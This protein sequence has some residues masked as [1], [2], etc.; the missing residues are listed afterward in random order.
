MADIFPPDLSSGVGR[1]RKNRSREEVRYRDGQ[2]RKQCVRCGG[3][4]HESDFH[5]NKQSK[6]DGLRA[7]CRFCAAKEDSVRRNHLG[8]ERYLEILGDQEGRC[9]VCLRDDPSPDL[10]WTI[11]HDHD[12]CPGTWSCGECVRGL[13]CRTCNMALGLL[14]ENPDVLRRGADYLEAYYG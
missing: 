9:K 11:D 7:F 5:P 10:M 2:G 12:C 6:A 14:K 1:V 4:F 13:L 3:W 8:M